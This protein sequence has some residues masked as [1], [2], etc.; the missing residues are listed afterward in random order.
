MNADL[1]LP[2]D[3]NQYIHQLEGFGVKLGLKNIQVICEALDHPER[4]FR[5]IIVGGTNGKGSVTAMVEQGL[6]KAG[7][8]T[9]RYTSPHLETLE[10]RFLINSRF[11]LRA[12]V[13]ETLQLIRTCVEDLILRKQL[14]SQPTFFEVITVAAFELFRRNNIEIAVLEVG[15]GGRF[16]A[17]NI[18]TPIAAVITSIELDHQEQLGNTIQQITIEKAGI[19]KPGIIVILGDAKPVVVNK[20]RQTCHARNA[21]CIEA[22]LGVMMTAH[23]DDGRTELSLTT[24]KNRY[25]PV[26]LAL[27][28]RHQ[29]DNA[30][31]AVRLLEELSETGIDV[32][33]SAICSALSETVWPGR[34]D[35]RIG[36]KD[37]RILLDTA[38]NPSA[39][40]ALVSY[41]REVYPCGLPIAFGA[42]RDK[43]IDGMITTL[44][45]YATRFVCTATRHKRAIPSITLS[46]KVKHLVPS[47]SV[48]TSSTVAEA[49]DRALIG[50]NTAC[51]TGSTYVVGEIIGSLRKTDEQ[52]S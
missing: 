20:V 15:L 28:G 11:V 41:I 30:V 27:R 6:R 31:V 21:R 38:H 29:I 40:A 22:S 48:E 32:P 5:S 50:A 42:M 24:P 10:E 12:E 47:M 3:I 49:L 25:G 26:S 33:T 43:D 52:G 36:R 19:I 18:V 8:R 23:L 7:Y 45:P 2:I 51:I 9:G 1:D 46:Q 39:M 14:D 35:L 4:T 44:A 13:A 16:D 37:K 17:T 34:L